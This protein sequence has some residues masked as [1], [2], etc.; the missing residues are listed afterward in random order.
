MTRPDLLRPLIL[1]SAAVFLLSSCGR[2]PQETAP[3]VPTTAAETTAAPIA[4]I[5]DPPTEA[6]TEAD[7]PEEDIPPEPGLVRSP[8]THEWIPEELAAK[9]PIAVMYPIDRKAQPQYGLDRVSVFY[10]IM[11]EGSMSRQMGIIEDWEDLGRIGNVRSIRDYFI[12][13]A[14]EW[15]SII[16]HFGGPEVFV[17]SLLTRKDV[18][19]ING[20]GGVMGSSYNAFYRIPKN[21]KSEH[22]AYTDGEHL[23]SAIDKAGFSR[24]HRED[25]WQPDRWKFPSGDTVVTLDDRDDALSAKEINMSRCFPVTKSTLSYNEADR[26]YYRNIYG[27]PQRDAVTKEQLSFTNVLIESA[28]SGNRGGSEYLYFH[29]LDSMKDGYYLTGGK[30]IHVT[31]MKNTDYEPTRF[32]D[33]N[34]E[35]ITLNTGRTMV[36]IVRDGKDSFTAD[37]EEYSL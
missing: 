7:A 1:C 30:M 9:R 20:V 32:F 31:W 4:V 18:E 37:G 26:K 27:A 14:L 25:Y 23:L 16:V 33:D 13:E 19:N 5:S 15:D 21:S 29:V 2:T 35:E 24:T 8:L 6:E 22:T 17:K 28:T 36:F 34:G 3:P 11:E 12:Y 10:E